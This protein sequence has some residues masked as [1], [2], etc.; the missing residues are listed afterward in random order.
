[1]MRSIKVC[2][3]KGAVLAAATVLLTAS[4]VSAVPIR[5]LSSGTSSSQSDSQPGLTQQPASDASSTAAPTTATTSPTIDSSSGAT[6]PTLPPLKLTPITVP[7]GTS[8]ECSELPLKSIGKLLLQS[9]S[10]SFKRDARVEVGSVPE[11]LFDRHVVLSGKL[12]QARV[13]TSGSNSTIDGLIYFT[14]G[15]WLGQLGAST[16]NDVIETTDGAS[17]TGRVRSINE[18]GID[19]QLAT[20][21]TQR[22]PVSSVQSITS[23]RAYRFSVPATGVTLPGTGGSFEG[24]ATSI[25]VA[26]TLSSRRGAIAVK[27]VAPRSTLR[28]TEGGVTKGQVA[29]VLMIDAVTTLVPFVAAPIVVGSGQSAAKRTLNNYNLGQQFQ[30]LQSGMGQ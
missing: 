11:W 28:G 15:T 18:S 12:I 5:V 9:G 7:A 27:P 10:I 22:I 2:S 4:A 19:F 20:A 29:S 23:P 16:Y 17:L 8:I 13:N 30:D 21:Q 3:A 25:V 1:M 6:N 14:D 24:D 26:P